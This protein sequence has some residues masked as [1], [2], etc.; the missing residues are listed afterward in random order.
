MDHGAAAD[1]G[2]DLLMTRSLDADVT[3]AYVRELAHVWQKDQAYFQ[4]LPLTKDN[5]QRAAR[6]RII[7][8]VLEDL[9]TQL[10]QH[11]VTVKEPV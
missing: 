10:E 1:S 6:A 8:V 9:A 7:A 4:G 3:I 5:Y 11:A 2:S